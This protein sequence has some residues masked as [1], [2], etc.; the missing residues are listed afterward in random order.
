MVE[1][2]T[3]ETGQP[4][5]P[6]PRQPGV[7]RL[8]PASHTRPDVTEPHSASVVQP[9]CPPVKQAAPA[10]SG[11][12]AAVDAGVHSVQVFRAGS[13]TKGAPQSASTRHCTQF[14]GADETSQRGSGL[15]QSLSCVQPVGEV[16]WPAPLMTLL[17]IWPVGQ[18]LRGDAPQPGVQ[19]P[20]GPLQMI[21]DIGPPQTASSSL[22]EQPHRPVAGRQAG[23]SPLQRVTLVGE[24]SVQAPASGPEVSQAGRAGSGQLGA[25]SAVQGPQV[26]VAVEQSGVTPPQS[27]ALTQ[28]TQ[29]PT[30]VEVSQSGRAPG[31]LL[32]SVGV[33]AP[34][35]PVDWQIGVEPPHCASLVQPWH[36]PLVGSQAGVVPLQADLFDVEQTPQAPLG[37]QAGVEPP[38]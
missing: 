16:H 17:H 23:F 1:L 13:Q 26:C 3:S 37:W 34:H 19:T 27:A 31:H 7:Q 33:Q 5:P 32:V 9:H 30:P 38:H 4:F 10:R 12:Q 11:L 14:P 22:P 36:V 28:P 24:H 29:T 25:P 15:A 18:S 20:L 35:A 21:P 8:M 2:Q 6:V